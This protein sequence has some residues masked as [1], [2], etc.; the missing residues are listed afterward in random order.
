MRFYFVS[1]PPFQT[2]SIPL[3]RKPRLLVIV[4][5][6]TPDL[7]GGVLFSDLTYGL[8]ERGFD[9]TVRCA[10]PYYPEWED[11]TGKNGLR[12]ER[13]D[14]QGVHV[15]RFGLYIPSNPNA[16]VPRLLY[17]ASFFA[18]LLRKWPHRGRFDLVMVFCPLIGAVAYGGLCKR[19]IGCPLWLNVQDLSAEAAAAGGI[20]GGGFMGRLLPRVQQALF[21]RADVW[22]SISPVMVERLKQIRS[23]S[24]PVLYFP[25]WLHGTLADAIAAL[26]AK[27]GH[28]PGRPVRL[29]YSG[30]IGTKQDLLRF[31][32]SLQAGDAPFRFRIQGTGSR[33]PELRAWAES[34]GDARFS[35]HALTDEAGLARAL[36]DADFFVITEKAGS[37]G[38]FIP[39]KL[40]PGL[41]SGT[42]ILAVCDAGSPLGREMVQSEPGPR[43]GWDDLEGVSS[44]LHHLPGPAGRYGAWQRNALER[45]RFYD[46]NALIDRYAE[47]IH[48]ILREGVTPWSRTLE[49]NTTTVNLMSDE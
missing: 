3:S 19:V 17:E 21:N 8:A 11:K 13:Y 23:R 10:Y 27:G 7:G 35:C 29:L 16:L 39:S 32:R 37:G 5:V 45:A 4:N 38:S 46:R 14:D 15:E 1:L 41:A 22:S 12:I 42:P 48:R 2:A 20:T 43:F 49:A 6:F 30:N 26:P 28:K 47:T 44:L 24:Q 34:T 25:N 33:A 31:C 36:Y 9:V 40:I 18:S